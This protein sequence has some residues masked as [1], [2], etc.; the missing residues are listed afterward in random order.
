M[1]G[2]CSVLR[3]AL[4]LS[5]TAIAASIVLAASPVPL[6]AAPLQPVASAAYVAAP[7]SAAPSANAVEQ[8]IIAYVKRSTHDI[9]VISP[10]GSGDRMLWAAPRPFGSLPAH[11]L[12]WRPDGRVLAFSSEH[13]ETCSWYQ[14]DVYTIGYNGANYRRVTNGPACAALAGLP[15]GSVTVNVA[16]Y[17]SALVQVYVQGA[18]GVRSVLS[19]GIVT[20]D[21]VTDL[22]VGV[23]QPAVAIYGEVRVLASPPLADVQP[24]ATVA[25][26]NLLISPGSGIE[27]FGPGKVSWTADGSALGYGM[28]TATAI[29]RLPAVPASGAGRS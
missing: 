16:N 25:G 21:N 17:T 23:L 10:D 11:D 5:S 13:E 26:G 2:V 22:G 12:A 28:R 15:K 6:P 8:G 29:R 4:R 9:H 14:S 20:F 24:G 3:H 19:N 18:P 27:S 7:A 1:I